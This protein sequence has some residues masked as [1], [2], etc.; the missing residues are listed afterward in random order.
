MRIFHAYENN[1][2]HGRILFSV[3]NA[4]E[5]GYF[6]LE[7]IDKIKTPGICLFMHQHS[8]SYAL[9]TFEYMLK[10]GKRLE[11]LLGGKLCDSQRQ[12]LSEAVIHS[13]RHKLSTFSQEK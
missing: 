4:L 7:H 13:Y 10:V 1:D 3:A 6:D 8:P 11:H 9:N 2:I 5:P 12:P